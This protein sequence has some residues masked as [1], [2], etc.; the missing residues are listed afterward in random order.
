MSLPQGVTVVDLRPPELRFAQPL[1]RLTDLPVLAVSLDQIEDGA[2]GLTPETG[3][4]VVIC[5]R[6]I[7]SGLAAKYLRADG[8]DAAAYP[9]GVPALLRER[10]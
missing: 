7:R 3:P 5:E 8:L 1:E 4:L 6:G 9:G 2:H 10:D